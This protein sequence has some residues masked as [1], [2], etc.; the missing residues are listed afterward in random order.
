[1]SLVYEIPEAGDGAGPEATLDQNR[2]EPDGRDPDDIVGRVL[3]WKNAGHGVA[4]ATVVATWGSSPRPMGGQLAVRED[5]A[6]EG[7]VSGGCIEGDVVTEALT[8]IRQGSFKLLEYGVS[9]E[10]AWR[11]GLA[12]GGTV[13][14]L[15]TPVSMDLVEQLKIL[16]EAR[17]ERRPAAL[18]LD[19]GNGEGRV[20]LK[21]GDT[22]D[23]ADLFTRERSGPAGDD[24][25]VFVCR[26]QPALRLFIVG[27]V[28][29]AQFLAPLAAR[30]GF[31]VTIVDPRDSW[32]TAE[33]FPD[34]DLDRRWPSTALAEAGL[35]QRT[36]VI[37]LCHDPKLDD[38]A[39]L[40]ALNSDVFYIGSLGSTR[41]H[42]KRRQRLLDEGVSAAAFE[43]IHGPLG[44]DIGAETPAEIAL[45]AMAE[46]VSALRRID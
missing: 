2:S 33:R 13:K 42:A 8:A 36:A 14:V 16:Q 44:L 11:V 3:D 28:H 38:P 5:G 20:V 46:V 31:E 4:L 10:D 18:V 35:D 7:S 41:T 23:D 12:C 40:E 22:A 1:V 24:P 45:S 21:D 9:D 6:F 25:G 19:L 39:L 29:I 43:R 17:S 26:F 32:A 27:A 15:V 34:T 30:L 37:T